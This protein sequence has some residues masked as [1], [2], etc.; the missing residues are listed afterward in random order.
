MTTG[1][2]PG[3]VGDLDVIAGARADVPRLPAEVRR[4]RRLLADRGL[5]PLPLHVRAAFFPCARSASMMLR[6]KLVT[7]AGECGCALSPVAGLF[8]LADGM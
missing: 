8:T 3:G 4:L 5:V 6:M 7:W 2:G 1:A